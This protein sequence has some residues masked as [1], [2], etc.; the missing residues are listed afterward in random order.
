LF[1]LPLPSSLI[2]C[3]PEATELLAFFLHTLLA[4]NG[5]ARTLASA[6]IALSTLTSNR[7]AS[8]VAK[9][10]VATDITQADNIL[11]HLPAKLAFNDTIAVDNLRYVA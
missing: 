11:G 10:A 7:Q 3:P 2:V 1:F 5:L 8:S 4:R 6:C 9:A